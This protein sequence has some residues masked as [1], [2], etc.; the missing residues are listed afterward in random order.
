MSHKD[1][2]YVCSAQ[3]NYSNIISADAGPKYAAL[4]GWKHEL[5]TEIEKYINY[6][7]SIIIDNR[8]TQEEIDFLVKFIEQFPT[9]LFILKVVDPCY[10]SEG[11]FYYKF[12]N[13]VASYKNVVF[14]CTYTVVEFL[15]RLQQRAYNTLIHLPYPFLEDK[16]IKSENRKHKIICSG[17][18]DRKIYPYRWWFKRVSL[19]IFPLVDWLAHPGYPDVSEKKFSHNYVG[20]RYIELL[21]TYS[22]MFLCPSRC[23]IELQKYLECAY[24]GCV[25]IG[26]MPHYYSKLPEIS[27]FFIDLSLDKIP[28][29]IFLFLTLILDDSKRQNFAAGYKTILKK[30][31]SPDILLERFYRDLSKISL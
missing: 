27:S 24:A 1:F 20:D 3:F 4:Y 19:F 30:E 22:F 28:K 13:A 17:A 26:I 11:H 15:E 25:P 6:N 7:K 8:I 29:S 31:R 10:E 18:I 9:Q 12:L 21:S 2:V 16:C 23:K 5:F 14:L